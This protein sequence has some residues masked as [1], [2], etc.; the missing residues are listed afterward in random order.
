MRAAFI[1]T[2][3]SLL[4]AA[5]AVPAVAGAMPSPA[6]AVTA[7][8]EDARLLAF[9]DAAF[10]S[11]LELRP[12]LAT[13]L[14]IKAGQDRWD[15]TTEAGQRRL[16][17]LH[18]SSVAMMRKQFDR[19]KL[20]PDGQVSYDMWADE[21]AR[22]E[23]QAKYRLYQP[24][25]YSTL[26]PANTQL[27]DFMINSHT[28]IEPADMQAWITRVR[29]IPAKLD[30][31]V[32]QTAA[33][34]KAGIRVPKFQVERIIAASQTILTGAPF[35]GAGDSPLMADA[36]A[37]VGKLVAGGKLSQTDG[38]AM[39]IE[40]GKAIVGIEP[41]YRRTIAW[42]TAALSKAP[43]GRVGAI[44]LPGG[45]AWYAAALQLNTTLPLSAA[46]VHTTG[47][48]EVKR[49]EAEQDALARSAGF[50]DRQAFYADRAKRFPPVPYDDASRA[51][52]LARAN[53]A[54]ARNRE[55]LPARFNLLP[56]F[57]AEVV[58]EPA[59]S[60]VPGGAAHA[61]GPSPDG[62]RPGRVYLHLQGNTLDP[63]KTTDLM[64][65]EGIPGHVMAGDIAVR[66][67][68]VPKFRTASGNVAY[69]EGWALYAE[70]LCKEMGAYPDTA[71]DFMRLD[72]ELFRAARL[73]T[74][75]GIH[76]LG[77]T[78]DQA[79]QYMT[80][81]GRL[82]PEQARSEVRRYI[83]L[84]GQATGYKI[85]MLEIMRLR[86]KAEGALGDRFDIKAF[87][88]LIV[89]GGS[90]PLPVLG[91]SVDAWIARQR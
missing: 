45:K 89:G 15:D 56:K 76:A 69:G 42:A 23:L 34:Q 31:A 6:V 79:V 91:R 72:A 54:V 64:C 47:L 75:T 88:D 14:G 63:A 55:L 27:P 73:V 35:A 57:G 44:S 48:A 49:I 16:I 33:S 61:S 38:D 22:M 17:A 29:G 83:T 78:E 77:W 32:A 43:S 26:Y 5:S 11:E 36:R 24:P 8:G 71:S 3:S 25:L 66:Q 82:P 2:A 87:D 52:Y 4:A 21:L 74:D 10:A 62:V 19:A 81:T 1:F 51:D 39:L 58:R 86:A 80:D 60:E 9:L 41:A 40:A 65:H 28:V 67:T 59:F 18:R 68:G 30:L 85:G 70:Q 90:M 50:A 12:Q 20:S 53:A 84:P 13:R 7:N 46:Q 37:K